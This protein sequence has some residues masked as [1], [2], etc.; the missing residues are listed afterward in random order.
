MENV[1]RCRVARCDR[2]RGPQDLLDGPNPAT[3][4]ATTGVVICATSVFLSASII[5]CVYRAC[6]WRD[7]ARAVAADQE[8][9]RERG[10]GGIIRRN[11]RARDRWSVLGDERAEE[12]AEEAREAVEIA[13]D[14]ELR[15]WPPG[16]RNPPA[17]NER[18]L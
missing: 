1:E 6:L 2:V 13:V 5:F 9:R 7:T 4:W 17:A 12:G 15:P 3:L 11:R 16:R 14:R 18:L 8:Q 10:G